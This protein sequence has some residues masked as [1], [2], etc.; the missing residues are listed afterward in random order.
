MTINEHSFH[1][2]G[3]RE[4]VQAKFERWLAKTLKPIR[5][6]KEVERGPLS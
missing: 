4:E 5:T 6:Q 3:E 2:E 1:A